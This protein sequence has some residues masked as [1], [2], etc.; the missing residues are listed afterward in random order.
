MTDREL[1]RCGCGLVRS[2]DEDRVIEIHA[3]MAL[4]DVVFFGPMLTAVPAR[5]HFE[6]PR[7]CRGCAVLYMLPKP[8]AP[9]GKTG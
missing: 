4:S 9:K 6:A 5:E 7:V 8:S 2:L 3:P 1:V